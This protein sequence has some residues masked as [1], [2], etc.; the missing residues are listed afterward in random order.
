MTTAGPSGSDEVHAGAGLFGLAAGDFGDR[1]LT[2]DLAQGADALGPDAAGL[3]GFG[4]DFAVEGLDD[5]EHGDLFRR[6]REGVA[7]AH[8]AVAG[9][10]TGPA[11]GREE[12]LEELL[13][14]LA[15]FGELFDRH[16][17]LPRTGQLGEGDDRI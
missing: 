4:A 1:R 10:Q 11:Q 17:S 3:F 16:R 13:G 12:L 2:E 5:L 8:A 9:Q 6:A 14:D 15:T 7:A